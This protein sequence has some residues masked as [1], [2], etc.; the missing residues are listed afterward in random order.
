MRG[1]SDWP[2]AAKRRLGLAWGGALGIG[3]KG[4][5]ALK[6]QD[7]SSESRIELIFQETAKFVSNRV[8]P[9]THLQCDIALSSIPRA[10]P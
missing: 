2:A 7:W 4:E 3:T 8:S 6:V 10:S 5:F 9:D 1:E